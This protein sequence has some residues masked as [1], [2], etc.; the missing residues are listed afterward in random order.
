MG[1]GGAVSGVYVSC[2]HIIHDSLANVLTWLR[3][4]HF[5]ICSIVDH[6]FWGLYKL[7]GRDIV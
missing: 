1:K 2:S 3:L 5:S 7:D 4:S 6:C